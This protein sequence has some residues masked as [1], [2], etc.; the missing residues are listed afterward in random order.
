[1]TIDANWHGRYARIVSY[2]S[3]APGIHWSAR[4]GL[5]GEYRHALAS[6]HFDKFSIG[7]GIPCRDYWY[8]GRSLDA[9]HGYFGLGPL[10]LVA[11]WP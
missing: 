3:R 7:V 1:M 4:I 6:I 9:G 11:W 10:L 2:P 5:T 8:L